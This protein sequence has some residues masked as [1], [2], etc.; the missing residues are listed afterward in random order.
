M[1]R[2]TKTTNKTIAKSIFK[3]LPM[4]KVE[5]NCKVTNKMMQIIYINVATLP[6]LQG[7]GNYHNF[8]I[9][10]NPTLNTTLATTEWNN[11]NNLIVYPMIP[12][13]NT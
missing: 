2:K 1:A 12:T 5:T 3:M 10:L 8:G 6:T 13:N 4:I 9:I 11:P 7:K